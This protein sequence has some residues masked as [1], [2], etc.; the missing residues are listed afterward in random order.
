MI[1]KPELS[2]IWLNNFVNQVSVSSSGQKVQSPKLP[3]V[4]LEDDKMMPPMHY[5]H[6]CKQSLESLSHELYKICSF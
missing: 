6:F 4:G 5:W 3:I 2:E 1:I